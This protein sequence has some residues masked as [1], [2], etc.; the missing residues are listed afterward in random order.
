[1]F[2]FKSDSVDSDALLW[3][4]MALTTLIDRCGISVKSGKYHDVFKDVKVYC[5]FIGYPRSGHSVIGS[6]IDAHP[7]ALIA[8]RLDSLKYIQAGLTQQEVFYLMLRNS[9]RFAQKGRALTGYKY[10]VPG[11][12]HGRIKTLQVIGDQEGKWTSIRL[13]ANPELLQ[14]ISDISNMKVKFIHVIRNPYD[15]ISTW[16]SRSMTRLSVT[17]QRYFSLCRKVARIKEVLDKSDVMDVRHEVFIANV[18]STLGKICD[19]L[20]LDLSGE[21]AEASAGIVYKSPHKSRFKKSWTPELIE[22]V[23][24]QME[25]FDFLSGYTFDDL[26]ENGKQQVD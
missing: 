15:N 4:K 24:K 1:M 8:H 14:R 10:H 18:K 7:N 2:T 16:S 12:W 6:I 3:V 19:F 20:G 9:Q 17:I 11:Q 22:T 25:E 13:S 26:Q 21:Y 5:M 23:K